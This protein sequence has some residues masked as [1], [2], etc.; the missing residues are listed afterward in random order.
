MIKQKYFE[1]D[2]SNI[3]LT[4]MHGHNVPNLVDGSELIGD[5]NIGGFSSDMAAGQQRVK[6]GNAEDINHFSPDVSPQKI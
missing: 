3:D 4:L 1:L 2:L 5:L 6:E